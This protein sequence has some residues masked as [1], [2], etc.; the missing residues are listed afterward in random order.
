MAC[1]NAISL[2]TALRGVSMQIARHKTVTLSYELKND[3]GEVL[4]RSAKDEPFAY[5]HGLSMIVPGLEK[6]LEGKSAGDSIS[7]RIE[8][9]HGYGNRHEALVHD[10][11]REKLKQLGELKVGMQMQV[12]T[13]A[14]PMILKIMSLDDETVT[15]DGN[16]PL[17]NVHLNFSI[18]VID[19]RDATPEEIAKGLK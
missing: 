12:D 14:G 16:H 18:D 3:E 9:E 5:I 7:V 4:D 17:A 19:V 1:L 10:I 11:P 2:Q 15:V 6:A 13:Q 8:P